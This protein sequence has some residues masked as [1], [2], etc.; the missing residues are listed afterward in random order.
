MD[1]FFAEETPGPAAYNYSSVFD[2]KK[3]PSS[4]LLLLHNILNKKQ[5]NI[6]LGNPKESLYTKQPPKHLLQITTK[7]TFLAH[8]PTN[9]NLVQ[10]S[11]T[12]Y[13]LQIQNFLGLDIIKHNVINELYKNDNLFFKRSYQEKLLQ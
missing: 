6:D 12:H 5:L 8:H 9:A 1:M 7:T 4:K 11:G 10:V 13:M 2:M 3:C